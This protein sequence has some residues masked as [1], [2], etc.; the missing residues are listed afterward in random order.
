MK[1]NFTK[2]MMIITMLSTTVTAMSTSSILMIWVMME[3]NMLSFMPMLTKSKPMKDQPMKY[4]IIQSLA[5]STMLMSVL[6]NSTFESP[7]KMSIMLTGS[8]LIKMGLMPFHMWVPM[9]MNSMSWETCL[10]MMTWQKIIPTILMSQMLKI[11]MILLPMCFSMIISPMIAMKQT[12][13]KKIL[14]YSSISN[15]PWMITSMMNSKSQFFMFFMVYSTINLMII[16]TMKKLN[17]IYINQMNTEST[18][19]KIS[20]MINILSM[21]G[22][23]PMIGFF[24][25]WMILQS[26]MKMSVILPMSMIISSMIST[27]VYIKMISPMWMVMSTEKKMKKSVKMSKEN[28]ININILGTM[29]LM[30]SK[31]F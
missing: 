23:P 29:I 30:M 9:I 5:S 28:D 14:A 15:S 8:L 6:L 24:P 19:K 7:I 22:M 16:K 1:M 12:S 2:T 21:S 25:K 31:S 17:L 20:M 10:I 13:M 27:F 11:K 3:I 4:F 18:K 26:T